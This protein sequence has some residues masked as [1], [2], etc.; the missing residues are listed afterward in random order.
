VLPGHAPMIVALRGGVVAVSEGGQIT[1]RLFVPGGFAEITAD[2][3]TILAD[4]ATPVAQL[5]RAEAETRI[6][7]AE[8]AMASITGESGDKV[9]LLTARVL[10]ARAMLAAA[11]AA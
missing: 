3:V 1:D 9:D 5:S 6:A 4:E 10:S 7:E 11:E 2:R 8:A